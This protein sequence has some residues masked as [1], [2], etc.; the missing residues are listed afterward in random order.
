MH[1][2]LEQ[3]GQND[4]FGLAVQAHDDPPSQTSE[5]YSA[6]VEPWSPQAKL[7]AEKAILG[8]YLSGHP[9]DAYEAELAQFTHGKVAT[10]KESANR[11][12]P[13]AGGINAKLAGLILDLRLRQNKNGKTMAFFY[14][15]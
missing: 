14:V 6:V 15:R 13:G 5:T 1:G 4:L 8:L 10:V 7:E 2:K 3:T 11:S 12:R 9:L